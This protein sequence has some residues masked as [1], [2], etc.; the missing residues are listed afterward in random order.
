MLLGVRLRSLRAPQVT[1][2]WLARLCGFP[3]AA[4]KFRFPFST[5]EKAAVPLGSGLPPVAGQHRWL[6]PQDRLLLRDNGMP[7]HWTGTTGAVT[8]PVCY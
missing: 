2:W 4:G 6:L 5:S 1:G 7:A 8:V 3:K